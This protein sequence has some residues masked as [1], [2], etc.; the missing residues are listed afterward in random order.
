MRFIL[1]SIF[2][3]ICSGENSKNEESIHDKIIRLEAKA[4]KLCKKKFFDEAADIYGEIVPL[5]LSTDKVIDI[6][7][8]RADCYFDN[9][10]WQRSEILY[11]SLVNTYKSLKFNKDVMY[12][13]IKSTYNLIPRNEECDISKCDDVIKL[14]DEYNKNFGK[15]DYFT[16]ILSEMFKKKQKKAV[17]N[18][19]NYY[20]DHEYKSV[21]FLCDEFTSQYTL[22]E[23]SNIVRFT[24]LKAECNIFI[25]ENCKYKG[26]DVNV[27][28]DGVNL[29]S[30][31]EEEEQYCSKK[32]NKKLGSYRKKIEK[33]INRFKSS[34]DIEYKN[35]NKRKNKL[36]DM[37]MSLS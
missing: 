18:L 27:Y 3:I 22:S 14:V 1:C 10:D 6:K 23:Y 33:I 28:N 37:V 2:F 19:K 5:V 13:L 32:D 11:S 35:K 31:I 26:D 8:K 25:K 20:D 30:K 29:L 4:E 24:R 36:K 7:I 21:I 17:K 9:K 15:D 16:D 12:K 34:E